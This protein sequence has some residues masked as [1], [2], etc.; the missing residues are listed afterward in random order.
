M[1]QLQVSS[2]QQQIVPPVARLFRTHERLLINFG[3]RSKKG[4][5]RLGMTV[6]G[7]AMQRRAGVERPLPQRFVGLEQT[8]KDTSEDAAHRP[9]L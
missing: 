1:K 4:L 6:E 3:A 9:E 8:D 2:Q 7:G 5:N